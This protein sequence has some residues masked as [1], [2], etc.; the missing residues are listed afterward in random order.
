MKIENLLTNALI[1]LAEM[2]PKHCL[3]EDVIFQYVEK[4]GLGLQEISRICNHLEAGGV[5]IVSQLE[6]DV[7][8]AQNTPFSK[9]E[10]PTVMSVE[11]L[12]NAFQ[13]LSRKDQKRCLD[14]LTQYHQ[15]ITSSDKETRQFF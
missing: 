11:D 8:V 2:N 6:Y 4:E 15:N 9:A 1:E 14:L 3:S 13:Q 7:A 10:Q 12:M 5:K